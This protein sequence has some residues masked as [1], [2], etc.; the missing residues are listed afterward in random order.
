MRPG[1]TGDTVGP[2]MGRFAREAAALDA[3]AAPAIRSDHARSRATP[4]AVAGWRLT[5]WLLLFG[6]CLVAP[7][8][9][10]AGILVERHWVTQQREIEQRLEQVA[11]DLADDLNRFLENS[12]ATLSVIAETSDF[13]PQQMPRL[14]EQASRWLGPLGLHML[15]RD[16]GGQQLMN[17]RVPWGTRLPASLQPDIDP[18]VRSTLKPHVSDVVAGAVAGQAVVTITVPVLANGQLNGFLHMS[19]NPERLLDLARGQALPPQWN[20]GIS[21]RKGLII[22]R[23]QEHQRYVGTPLPEDL[24][25]RSRQTTRAFHTVNV[26]GVETIRAARVSRVSGW[27]VSANVP[28]AVARAPMVAELWSML[29]AGLV[30]LAL[31]AGLAFT[32]ARFVSRPIQEIARF[33]TLV[34]N[35]VIP[36]ALASPLR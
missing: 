20:T 5:T 36:P 15:F 17:T 3:A 2:S 32:V 30:L 6:G 25:A 24:Q 1:T 26:E 11:A 34:E 28:L 9:G 23:L 31:V 27:L 16:V 22:T 10:F 13:S 35:D 8:L 12:I 14:H 33:G 19:I 29:G 7:A 21:D 18:V 4:H